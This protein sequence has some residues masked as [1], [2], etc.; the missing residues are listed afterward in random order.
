[1]TISVAVG[2]G[3]EGRVWQRHTVIGRPHPSEHVLRR[4][5]SPPPPPSVAAA[6]PAVEE[7]EEGVS[8][9]GSSIG[10]V[11]GYVRVTC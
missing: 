6:A 7:E 5:L 3:A 8:S 4:Q 11:Y 1:M 10:L 9:G 2:M